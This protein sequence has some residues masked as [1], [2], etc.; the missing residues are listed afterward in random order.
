MQTTDAARLRMLAAEVLRIAAEM[1]DAN[2]KQ[3]MAEIAAAYTRLAT[4]VEEREAAPPPSGDATTE[5][6]SSGALPGKPLSL[7]P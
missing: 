4:Y 1:T 7:R 2:C 6:P 5:P 3:A